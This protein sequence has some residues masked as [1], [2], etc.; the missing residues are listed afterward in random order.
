MLLIPACLWSVIFD[1]LFGANA[2][3]T[4]GLSSVGSDVSGLQYL[5]AFS[6]ASTIVVV[7][8]NA[9]FIP[10]VGIT[11]VIAKAS[12]EPLSPKHL[13]KHPALFLPSARRKCFP[14]GPRRT[15]SELADVIKYCTEYLFQHSAFRKH[16]FV[17]LA[18]PVMHFSDAIWQVRAHRLGSFPWRYRHLLLLRPGS[19][20]CI[21]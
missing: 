16:M 13:R 6:L 5:D 3:M 20:R 2:F 12:G 14:L 8:L 10:Y 7:V 21:R 11:A 4:S 17:L 15:P 1:G 18:Y 9:V 19:F